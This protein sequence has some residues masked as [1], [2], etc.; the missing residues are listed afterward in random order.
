MLHF[1][2]DVENEKLKQKIQN[3]F[4]GCISKFSH[5]FI[6]II[7]IKLIKKYSKIRIC[8]QLKAQVIL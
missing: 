2:F 4:L 8:I 6:L 3:I 5:A 7:I 1:I